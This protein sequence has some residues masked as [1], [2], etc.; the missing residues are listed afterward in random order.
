MRRRVSY[1]S[2]T[3]MARGRGR[4]VS[5]SAANDAGANGSGALEESAG[6]A[7]TPEVSLP[8]ARVVS[9]RARASR[10]VADSVLGV[11]AITA[12]RRPM[13]AMGDSLTGTRAAAGRTQGPC[14]GCLD[15]HAR[16]VAQVPDQAGL[17][18]ARRSP[19]AWI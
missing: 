12:S 14:R 1:A 8:T 19:A 9:G 10:R 13:D 16:T 7:G 15:A 3:S 5:S 6:R 2:L 18:H 17:Q 4:T 11:N